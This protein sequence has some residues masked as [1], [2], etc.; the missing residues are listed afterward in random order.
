ME[1]KILDVLSLDSGLYNNLPDYQ[2]IFSKLAKY[3]MNGFILVINKDKYQICEIEF[4]LNDGIHVDPF[5]HGDPHQSKIG[6]W[7][8][9][10]QN[11]KGYKSGSF[12]GVDIT[13]GYNKTN[14]KFLGGILIRSIMNL[15]NDTVIEG[16]CNVVN[17]IL[18]KNSKKTIDEF[19]ICGIK[20]NNQ[21]ISDETMIVNGTNL[22]YLKYD[23]NNELYDNDIY[24]GPRVGLTLKNY[25]KE[26]EG[27]LMNDYRFINKLADIKNYRSGMILS[28]IESGIETDEISTITGVSLSNINKYIEYY[29]DTD[30]IKASQYQG[31]KLS[32]KDLCILQAVCQQ[33][34]P[35]NN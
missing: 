28:M 25:S 30:G 27:F 16:P 15:A 35:L 32:V 21:P 9:H 3:L 22:L 4:Y 23:S 19:V 5:I 26:R 13:F 11:S 17:T 31:M 7:Y 2:T 20:D 1:N 8:F 14:K 33:I 12:K 29:N 18:S 24:C 10:R 6:R 34:H